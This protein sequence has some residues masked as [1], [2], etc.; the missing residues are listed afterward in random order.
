MANESVD[1]MLPVKLTPPEIEAKGKALAHAYDAYQGVEARK[2]SA[3]EGYKEELDGWRR[4]MGVLTRQIEAERESRV[5]HCRWID[6][7]DHNVRRLIRQD[8]GT[9]V[10]E[11]TIPAEERQTTML[12]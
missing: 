7:L 4:E 1:R 6:D 12:S 11:Q 2:K 8:D 3:N 10:D 9:V 5:V